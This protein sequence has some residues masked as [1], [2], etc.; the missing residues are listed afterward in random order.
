LGGGDKYPRLSEAG[1][2]HSAHG[3][4]HKSRKSVRGRNRIVLWG[5]GEQKKGV[6]RKREN[7]TKLKDI[8]AQESRPDT[9][10]SMQ[11]D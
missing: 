1:R 8:H 9:P 10:K 3:K 5:W 11:N 7:Q 6:E 2:T 4:N